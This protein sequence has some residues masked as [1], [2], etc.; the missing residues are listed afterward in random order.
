MTRGLRADRPVAAVLFDLDRFKEINDRFGHPIGDAVIQA[1]A[2]A[3]RTRLR[4]GDF[5]ARLGGEEFARRP[6]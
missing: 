3:A 1:F 4:A 6:A 5:V 2:D